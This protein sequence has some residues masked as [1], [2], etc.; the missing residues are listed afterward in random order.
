MTSARPRDLL[1]GSGKSRTGL[2]VLFIANLGRA[3]IRVVGDK[4][5]S[6]QSRRGHVPDSQS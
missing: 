2:V 1:L 4:L 3:R 6:G 5:R